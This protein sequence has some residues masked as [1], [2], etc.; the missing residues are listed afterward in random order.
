MGQPH[1]RGQECLGRMRYYATWA[2]LGKF[3]LFT[4]VTVSNNISTNKTSTLNAKNAIQSPLRQSPPPSRQKIH[5]ILILIRLPRPILHHNLGRPHDPPGAILPVQ[6]ALIAPVIMLL[7][8]RARG[9]G[10]TL[11]IP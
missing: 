5:L 10:R 6:D 1:D 2:M 11:H 7:H 4:S 8:A 9:V 3:H